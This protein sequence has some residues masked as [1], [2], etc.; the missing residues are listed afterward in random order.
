LNRR[1][2]WHAVDAAVVAVM[3][4]IVYASLARRGW[5]DC[6]RWAASLLRESSGIGP[7]SGADLLGNVF[8]YWLLGA[9]V[10]LAWAARRPGG[11]ARL[12]T[13]LVA[14]A[15]VTLAGMMLSLSMEAAQACLAGRVSAW[16]DVVANTVG[17]A[18]GWF[19]AR[20]AVPAGSALVRRG[21]FD[22]GNGPLLAIVSMAVFAW[23][24]AETA[25]WVPTPHPGMIAAHATGA[26]DA[27]RHAPLN[28]WH[29]AQ[30]GGCWLAVGGALA[31][32]PL[33][34]V[35]AL[36]LLVAVGLG[37]IGWQLLLP[38]ATPPVPEAAV[39]LAG[40]LVVLAL[41][42]RLGRRPC[43]L[44]A[45]A[46]SIV[47]ITA[48]QLEPGYGVPAGRFVWRLMLLAG[49][50]INGIEQASRFGG[51]AATVVAA[52]TV[53]GGRPL[54]WALLPPAWLAL[55]EWLQTDLPGHAAELSPPVIALACVG[56]ATALLRHGRARG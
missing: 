49:D 52:G 24:L 6:S 1:A 2:G 26:W 53:L 3:V 16:L 40:A 20:A 54:G 44:L 9:A 50:P 41:A 4:G 15:A 39:A 19:S 31:L 51:F 32:P 55:T 12:G 45:I 8:A 23:V 7:G 43:A 14:G 35:R 48:W 17:T 10:G 29:L 28:P 46:G 38:R 33:R 36:P 5:V 37:V 25:P 56:V 13:A 21:G 30:Q 27:L 18:L 42:V 11:A 34:P 22:R 47:A